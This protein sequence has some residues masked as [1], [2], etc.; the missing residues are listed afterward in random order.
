[1]TDAYSTGIEITAQLREVVETMEADGQAV[2]VESAS[3]RVEAG[4]H[5]M[6]FLYVPSTKGDGTA[7]FVTN[8][9]IRPEEA[10]SFCRP[11]AD[12]GGSKTG[13]SRSRTISLR[14]PP[15]TIIA[16]GFSTSCSRCCSTMSGG[17]PI[18]LLKTCVDGEMD[19]APVLTAGEYVE[20]VASALIPPD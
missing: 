1:M 5:S 13:T 17:S 20:I 16:C 3:V 14:R 18:S 19:Y 7:V 2:A 4:S 10:E 6:W 12:A 8:L 9:S 15:G 11:T